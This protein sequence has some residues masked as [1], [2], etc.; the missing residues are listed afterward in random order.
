MQSLEKKES[1]KKTVIW[2]SI[3]LLMVWFVLRFSVVGAAAP[4]LI[5]LRGF[6][7]VLWSVLLEALPFVML[8]T[9][10]SSLIQV[11]VSE[12][13][14]LK[15]LPKNNFLRLIFAA[16]LGLV[17][18]VC[19]CAII[20]ITRGLIKKGMPIGPAIAFMIAT[21]IINPIVIFSTY[22]A[23]PSMPEMALVRALSGFLGAV[24]IG[25]LVGSASRE[26][27]LKEGEDIAC[28]C[29]IDGHDHGHD[30]AHHHAD[31]G[32]AAEKRTGWQLVKSVL[33]HTNGELQ[34]V[35]MY[36]IFGATISAAVQIL[37]PTDVLTSL[38]SGRVVSI[39]VMMVL[40]IVLSICSEADAFIGSTFLFQFSSASILAFLIV[41]P[42]VDI[43]NTL[44]MLGAF[45]KKFVVRLILTILAVCF[46]LALTASYLMGGQY[47]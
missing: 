38:G 5:S 21:P 7:L 41:G 15:V 4:M 28:A 45:K 2:I 35:G 43:K 13:T 32:Q 29:G 33:A 40:A 27:T 14:I 23:F 3:A 25:G 6:S 24:L 1:L 22:N 36:L 26:R 18:P 30:H 8:G 34:S 42:M 16:L 11:F 9:I 44:M 12:E 17:F 37:V 39:L 46:L 31:D 10:I 19:E 47:V 20:P